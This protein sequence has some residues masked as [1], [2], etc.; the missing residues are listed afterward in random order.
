ME[1]QL[2]DAARKAYVALKESKK[3]IDLQLSAKQY[4]EM[5]ESVHNTT[6]NNAS[7]LTSSYI[8]SFCDAAPLEC[9]DNQVRGTAWDNAKC[10]GVPISKAHYVECPWSHRVYL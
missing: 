5:G 7:S 6:N 2:W 10:F 1:K 3:A 4:V 8:G 9:H